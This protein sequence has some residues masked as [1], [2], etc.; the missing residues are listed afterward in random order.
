MEELNMSVIGDGR[1][2][3]AQYSGRPEVPLPLLHYRTSFISCS[4]DS[5]QVIE[6]SVSTGMVVKF[7]RQ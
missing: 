6:V 2:L 3:W 1:V 5:D 7:P 4:G